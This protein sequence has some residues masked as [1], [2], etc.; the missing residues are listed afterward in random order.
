V[1]RGLFLSC[2]LA[3]AAL[4]APV[5]PA[6]GQKVLYETASPYGPVV[7]TEESDGLRTLRFGRDGVRQSVVK[8]GDP[9]HLELSYAKAAMAGLALTGEPARFLVVGLGGGSLPMFLRQHYPNAAIDVVDINPAVVNVARK[10]LGFREDRLLNAHVRDGRQFIE[11]V[12]APYDVIFLDAFGSRSIPE[13]LTTQ[14]FLQSVRRAITPDGVVIGNVWGRL[15]NPLYDSMVR[16]YQEVFDELLVLD[17]R[18]AEN[19]ILLALPRKPAPDRAELVQ[20]TRDLSTARGFPFAVN[21]AIEYGLQDTRARNPQ[22]RVLR[23]RD[24]KQRQPEPLPK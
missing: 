16:T 1:T 15:A 5:P 17:V 22:E 19:K 14:E 4:V 23:D 8:P 13:H 20:L 6:H 3:C 10:F 18:D 7:V 24:I 11:K 12:Q 21:E 9:G 2:L